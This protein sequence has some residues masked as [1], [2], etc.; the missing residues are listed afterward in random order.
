VV[1]NKVLVFMPAANQEDSFC[2]KADLK[3]NSKTT[4]DACQ[5]LVEANNN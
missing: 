3:S 4:N 1:P 2:P 5:E